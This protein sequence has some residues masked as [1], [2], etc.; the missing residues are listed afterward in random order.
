VRQRAGY[1]P[2]PPRE[3]APRQGTAE[4][5]HPLVQDAVGAYHGAVYLFHTIRGL[6]VLVD[7]DEDDDPERRE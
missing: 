4:K 5:L 6:F 3:R 7:E 2:P 1:P